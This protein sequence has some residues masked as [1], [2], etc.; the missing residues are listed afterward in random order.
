LHGVEDLQSRYD[1]ACGE[2]LDLELV[3][4]GLANRL[5]HQLGGAMQCV[6]RLRPACRHAPFDLGHRLGDRR[7]R[8]GCSTCHA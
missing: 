4:G 6:E 8:H 3:V 7:C 1:F 5:G 2:W